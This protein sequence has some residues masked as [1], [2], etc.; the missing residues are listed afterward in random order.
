M[1]FIE[2]VI[3]NIS[4]EGILVNAN[5]ENIQTMYHK[6]VSGYHNAPPSSTPEQKKKLQQNKLNL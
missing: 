5:S 4:L 6:V 3:K 1:M 2:T